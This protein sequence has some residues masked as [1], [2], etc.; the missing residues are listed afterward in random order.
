MDAHLM[1]LV[2][3]TASLFAG[4]LMIAGLFVLWS[5]TPSA[6]L[7]LA[8]A[9]EGISM[10]FRLV[11]AVVPSMLAGMPAITLVWVATGLMVAAGVMGYALEQPGRR[12]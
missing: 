9:G 4:I 8:L 5:K 11:Y 1:Q 6:W 2:Q 10:L 3:A 12:A 7:L